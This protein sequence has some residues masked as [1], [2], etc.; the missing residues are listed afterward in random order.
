M[1]KLYGLCANCGEIKDKSI[2]R[3]CHECRADK[4]TTIHT[5]EGYA[6]VSAKNNIVIGVDFHRRNINTKTEYGNNLSYKDYIVMSRF[7]D[8][9]ITIDHRRCNDN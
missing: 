5:E 2:Y 3:Y 6:I 7:N 1:G 8:K 9:N 4:V